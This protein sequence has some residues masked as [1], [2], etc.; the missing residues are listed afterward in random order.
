MKKIDIIGIYR[1]QSASKDAFLASLEI[2]LNNIDSTND[3][4]IMGDINIC[5]LAPSPQ[6]NNYLDLMCSFGLIPHIDQVTRPNPHG[7]GSLLDHTW[8]NFGLN[9]ESGVFNEIL[10]SDHYISFT[11]LPL[12]LET[13]K[14]KIS[15]RDHSEVN[16][17]KM[18]D[19]LINFRHFFPLLTLT[20]DLNSKFN[21]LYDEIDRIYKTCCPLRTKE[22]S[23]HK[24]KKPWITN[25]I[26]A[27]IR[28]KYDLYKRFKNG[29]IT[30]ETLKIYKNELKKKMKKAKQ[31]YFRNKYRN[32]QGDSGSTWK[33]TNNILGKK[34][35]TNIP[36]I[37]KHNDNFI[38]DHN[39]MCKIFNN[40][41]VNLGANLANNITGNASNPLSYL[42]PRCTNSFSFTGTTSQEVFNIIKQFKNKKSSLNNIP[43]V[44]FKKISHIISPL[45]AEIFNESILAG[46]FPEKLKTG[47][48]IPLFKEGDSTNILNYRPI[49]T[50]T[51]YSKIFEKLVHKRMIS[52]ISKYN[53]IKPS[54]F[55]F[56]SN[57]STSDAIIDFLENINDSFSE[58]KHYL[59]V[60]LDFSK[61]FDTICHEILLKKIEIMGF[62]GPIH[63]WIRSYLTNRKQF[64]SI[65]EASSDMLFTK[66]GVPQG[67]TLGPLLFILYINDMSNSLSYLKTIHFADD[68]TLHIS[69]NKNENIAPRINADLAVINTWLISNKLHLNIDKTKYMIFSMRDKPLDLSLVIGNSHI[70]RTNVKKFLGMYIDERLTFGDHTNKIC[71][72]MSRSV[73]VMRRLKAFIPRDILKK[74]FY[75]FIYSKFTYGIIC[76]GSAYQN[77]VQRVKKVIDRSL[78]LVFNTRFITSELLKHEKVLDF[79][80]A[81]KYFCTIK[82]YKILH[83]NNHPSLAAKINSFQTNHTHNT[84]AV[85]NENLRLPLFLSTK[86]QNSFIY[87]GIDFWNSIPLEL[88]NI[89]ED[90]NSFKRLLKQ[91]LIT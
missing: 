20:L 68:S 36:S 16:I 75:S 90:V 3:L 31:N 70:E 58:N 67:S 74:L 17:L 8:T 84:R 39:T 1:P 89:P 60:Y 15:F 64:V 22:V 32:C 26:L 55:G 21:L 23:S 9:F 5:G 12:E 80:M 24:L 86:C 87:R 88:R 59:S 52:F 6:L 50:L 76:Y 19:A 43:I 25:E 45:L 40:F 33:I 85:F 49:T 79:D 42:G 72:K 56:Q 66:M 65:G 30:Y 78:K 62:R 77:Q 35:T 48:V 2:L 57:K 46:I 61:A 82:M 54:Q 38:S 14:K 53:I 69:M 47:R 7:H 81:Y 34:N 73:G 4:I 51:I 63:N 27:D 91:F 44:V 13:E 11:F 71:L 29:I 18:V 28:V 83:L 10:I 37:I 41:F